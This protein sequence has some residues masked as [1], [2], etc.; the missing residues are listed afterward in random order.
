[1]RKAMKQVTRMAVGLIAAVLMVACAAGPSPDQLRAQ[2]TVASVQGWANVQEAS[3]IEREAASA[4]AQA[5]ARWATA[6]APTATPTATAAPTQTPEPTAT[7]VP[8]AM[9]TAT[10][11]PTATAVPTQTPEP[12]ATPAPVTEPAGVSLSGIAAIAIGAL[13]VLFGVGLIGRWI[14]RK[15][16]G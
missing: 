12:T 2:A 10:P 7:A 13:I 1:M 9:P 16:G 6:N 3:R 14:W 11:A 4:T 15:Y 5:A 8:T